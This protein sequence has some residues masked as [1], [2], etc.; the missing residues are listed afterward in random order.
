[1]LE[2]LI[3]VLSVLLGCGAVG[4]IVAV[5]VAALVAVH[6]EGKIWQQPPE[7]PYLTLWGKFKVYIFNVIWMSVCFIMSIFIILH[8]GWL[9]IAGKRQQPSITQPGLDGYQAERSVAVFVCSLVIGKTVVKG[10]EH[11]E[12]S[13]QI[14]APVIIA[15]HSSQIDTGVVYFLNKRFK[16]I[17]K[18]TVRFLPGVGQLMMLSHHVF[19]NRESSKKKVRKATS[20]ANLYEKSN[21]AVQ[22]GIPMF[23]FPQG[24]RCMTKRFPFKNGAFVVAKSNQTTLIPISIDIPS[25]TW[26]NYYPLSRSAIPIITLTVHPPVKTSEEDDI[27][28]LKQVCFDQIYSVLPQFEEPKAPG[29]SSG[30]TEAKK[31]R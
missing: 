16:W 19:I 1:M 17:A 23:F 15:N 11:L 6:Q 22:S 28:K 29:E 13:P 10:M 9:V 30:K 26:N 20:V 27:E 4:F 8:R 31:E 2:V 12:T 7:L 24:H 18:H 5:Q 21:Q 14:P 25:S 3:S